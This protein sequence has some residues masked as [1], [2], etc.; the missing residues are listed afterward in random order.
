LHNVV[1]DKYAKQ[2]AITPV[3]DALNRISS[4]LDRAKSSILA[5][6]VMGEMTVDAAVEEYRK[7]AEEL[8][9]EQVLKELN[10]SG[11]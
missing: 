10:G 11:Y 7:V 1:T 3:S 2:V 9:V 6:V 4:D 5:R 8:N